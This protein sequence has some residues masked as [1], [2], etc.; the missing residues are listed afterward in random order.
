MEIR[1][2]IQAIKIQ[3]SWLT[4]TLIQIILAQSKKISNKIKAIS[5]KLIKKY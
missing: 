3:Y 2:S 1:K 5:T 4:A